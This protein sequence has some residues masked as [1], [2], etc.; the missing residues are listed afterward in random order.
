MK[1]TLSFLFGFIFLTYGQTI[2]PLLS[3]DEQAQKI[4]V[5]SLY[6]SFSLEEKVG[7]LFMPMVFTERDS[8]HYQRTLELVKNQKV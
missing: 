5:D 2:D 6:N 4:W 1:Y 3:Q 8:S 7:Q